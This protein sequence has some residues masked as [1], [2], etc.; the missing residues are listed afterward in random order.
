MPPTPCT[1]ITAA[2]ILCNFS[3]RRGTYLCINHDPDYRDQQAAQRRRASEAAARNRKLRAEQRASSAVYNLEEWVLADRSSIQA[4]L[5]TV[6]RL[7]LAGRLP[8]ARARNLLRALAIAVRNFDTPPL[9]T[10]NGRTS[11]HNL[12]RYHHT[13]Q[14]L[15]AHLESLLAEAE[16]RDAARTS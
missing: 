7:E 13:R 9:A 14:S 2:G 1:A 8:S 12:S 5:D 11:R 10:A 4:L 3:A 6:I 16:S 15:D